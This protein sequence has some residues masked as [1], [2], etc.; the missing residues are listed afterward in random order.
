MGYAVDIT[1]YAII[2]RHLLRP[3]VI[4]SL[5]Q[6]LAAIN[7]WCLKWHKELNPKKIKFIVVNLSRI[8]ASGYGDLTLGGA[9]L[10]EV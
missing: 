4:E 6:D 7:S 9:D 3:Q 10:E 1:N 8:I 2:P 5:N